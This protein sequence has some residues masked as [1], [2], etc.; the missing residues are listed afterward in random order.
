MKN[1]LTF[2]EIQQRLSVCIEGHGEEIKIVLKVDFSEVIWEHWMVKRG[3][4]GFR[5][6]LSSP[7]FADGGHTEMLHSPRR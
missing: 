1:Y 4:D 3:A 7:G 2:D 6:F 5:D